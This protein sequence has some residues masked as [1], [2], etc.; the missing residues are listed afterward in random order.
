[1]TIEVIVCAPQLQF[2]PLKFMIPTYQIWP[3]LLSR[4][5]VKYLFLY[6]Y[7]Y[8]YIINVYI[9][10]CFFKSY[11]TLILQASECEI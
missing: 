2:L 9:Y 4:P 10:C 7:I 1:M 6:Y 8:S 3:V 5:T 11:V